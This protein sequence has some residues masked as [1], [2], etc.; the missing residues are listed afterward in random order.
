MH[1]P[2]RELVF[3][4]LTAFFNYQKSEIPHSYKK[5]PVERQ[6]G[7]IFLILY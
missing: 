2:Y 3:G 6:R 5:N 1:N 7:E 4:L